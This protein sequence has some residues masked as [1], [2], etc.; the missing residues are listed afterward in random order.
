MVNCAVSNKEVT[1]GILVPQNV[2]GKRAK[3]TKNLQDQYRK[4]GPSFLLWEELYLWSQ[5]VTMALKVKKMK[6]TKLKTEASIQSDC[7][8]HV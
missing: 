7:F 5:D 4:E 3:P 8:R 2:T 6:M 1:S